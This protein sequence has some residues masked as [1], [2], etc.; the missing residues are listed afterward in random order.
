MSNIQWQ[1]RLITWQSKELSLLSPKPIAWRTIHVARSGWRNKKYKC[2]FWFPIL[3]NHPHA[4]IGTEQG[5]LE[6]VDYLFSIE[7]TPEFIEAFNVMRESPYVCLVCFCD[8]YELCHRRVL[9]EWLCV[10]FPDDFK[11]YDNF[12]IILPQN[13]IKRGQL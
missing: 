13:Y 8:D 12:S 4:K 3:G 5:D 2:D 1:T 10:R 11:K 6:Y 9:V 7:D